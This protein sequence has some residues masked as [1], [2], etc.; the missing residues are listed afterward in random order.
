MTRRVG[1]RLGSARLAR[2]RTWLLAGTVL[3]LICFFVSAGSGF[4]P[5]DEAWFLQILNRV[6][7]GDVLYQDVWFST[8]PLAIY[9]GTAFM[10]VL[11]VEILA[12]KAYVV[13][14]FVL[15]VLVSC[16]IDR[17]LGSS[18]KLH[19][20]LV[21]ALLV[22][23]LP[24]QDAPYT[25]LAILFL[26]V[27]FSAAL[28]WRSNW[29]P[30]AGRASSSARLAPLVVGGTAAGL[31]FASK[32]NVGLFA[33][34]AFALVVIV[35]SKGA[36][37]KRSGISLT[38]LLPFLLAVG[39]VF[40]PVVLSGGWDELIY[41]GFQDQETFVRL[42][43]ISYLDG[44]GILKSLLLTIR[45]PEDL[46]PAFAYSSFLV[47][48]ATF[49]ALAVARIVKGGDP[50]GLGLVV[51]AFVTAGFLGVFP[52]ADLSHLIYVLPPVFLG[53]GYGLRRI[54]PRLPPRLSRLLQAGAFLALALVLMADVVA[55]VRRV[56][57]DL[58][59]VS[60]L[61]HFSGALNESVF[62]AHT[63]LQVQALIDEIGEDQ[64]FLLTPK[65]SFYYLATGI[66]NPTRFDYPISMV[67]GANGQQ[68]VIAAVEDSR[69]D[70]ICLEY[71]DWPYQLRATELVRYMQ[72]E[73]H[74][75][76]DVGAC[77]IYSKEL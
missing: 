63:R 56:S 5:Y 26:L 66:Q 36:A 64:P 13:L 65:A 52:R 35:E 57:S 11:G 45:S 2:A 58:Y 25:S 20:G 17:Q 27:S 18:S 47:P 24:R 74:R 34:V 37:I 51:V 23:A 30:E 21:L 42:G 53:L 71:E 9:G 62:E 59:G 73:M 46:R 8:T 19:A 75:K 68:E 55:S 7:S 15:I 28:T 72:H 33:L 76:S 31:S 3:F 49:G 48:I 4:S 14:I 61:S 10:A 22:Y 41:Y 29:P 1:P 70:V 12:L 69:I 43:S 38:V 16:R 44:F 40:L 32:Q 6:V 39:V 60:S 77:T 50:H 54:R 67:F